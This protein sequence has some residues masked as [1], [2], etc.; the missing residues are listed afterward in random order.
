MFKYFRHCSTI[1]YTAK[2]YI[3]K[4]IISLLTVTDKLIPIIIQ[5]ESVGFV[6]KFIVAGERETFDD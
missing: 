5:M 4:V 6:G 2:K 1:N 3:Y